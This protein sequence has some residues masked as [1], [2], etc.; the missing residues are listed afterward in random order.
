M[1]DIDK[2]PVF[3]PRSSFLRVHA[4]AL[5]SA[6]ARAQ[7][8]NRTCARCHQVLFSQYPWTWEGTHRPS[9]SSPGGIPGGSTINSG[10]ARD[11]LLGGCASQM[12]CTDC[13]DP[14]APDNQRRMAELDGAAGNAVCLHC[15][16]RFAGD[17]ALRAHTHHDPNGPGAMCLNCHM[18]RKN[19]SLDNRLTRYHRIGSPTDTARVEQD[20]PLECALCHPDRTVEQLVGT[21]ERWW[22]KSYSRP[23]LTR[24]YG[25]MTA[26]VM[27]ATLTR[28]KLHEQ[29]VAITILGQHKMR[30]AVP[31][32]A[33]RLTHPYPI[34]RYYAEQALEEV[35]GRAPQIDLF[36]ANEIIRAQAD[37][38][39]LQTGIPSTSDSGFA[40]YAACL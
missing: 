9:L 30:A 34:L 17:T 8:I 22:N 38:F 16:A 21:M 35:L 14:H 1:S 3:E 7:R 40:L 27:L 23:A 28:G 18:P 20:R 5:P 37:R 12:S 4:P 2:K 29:A 19:M 24:L 6:E 39:L 11:F 26:N 15:H 33:A 36:Q 31:L 32:L 13:H 10:E 25:E